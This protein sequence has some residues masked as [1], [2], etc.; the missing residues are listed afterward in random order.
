MNKHF[1]FILPFLFSQFANAALIK[2]DLEATINGTFGGF[3]APKTFEVSYVFDTDD[4]I[5]QHSTGFRLL[6]STATV[7]GITYEGSGGLLAY[8][9]NVVTN[10]PE[11]RVS[12]SSAFNFV[13]GPVAV[14]HLGFNLLGPDSIFS[15]AEVPFLPDVSS[16]TFF[17]GFSVVFTGGSCRTSCSEQTVLAIDDIVVTEV[18]PVPVPAAVWLMGSGL[19]GLF[20]VRRKRSR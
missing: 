4:A 19:A 12:G 2:F 20:A 3:P 16:F 17:R 15:I 10:P 18:S 5:S 7:D 11:D 9:D 13:L 14:T 1:A 8:S 6:S